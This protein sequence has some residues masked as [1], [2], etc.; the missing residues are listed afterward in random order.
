VA[1]PLFWLAGKFVFYALMAAWAIAQ[2]RLRVARP[3]RF[4][5]AYTFLRVCIGLL[6]SL[7]ILYAWDRLSPG[8]GAT[9]RYSLSFGIVRY[10]E[11][12]AVLGLICA[13]QRTGGWVFGLR[14][15]VWILAGVA[16]N[17]LL[18]RIAVW[19]GMTDFKI[20]C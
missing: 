15:Q 3:A 14:G 13:W 17:V 4:V 8:I 7:I 11:W 6:S 10:F 12:L 19:S 5:V 18:D 2:F 1:I 9:L 16:G 20:G